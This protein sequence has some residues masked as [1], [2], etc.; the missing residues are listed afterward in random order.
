MIS[1]GN[2][3]VALNKVDAQRTNQFAFYSKILS[4]S[5]Q[6]LYNLAQCSG[7]PLEHYVWLLW[8]VKESAYK[9]LKRRNP[10]IIFSPAK[11][12]V[13]DAELCEAEPLTPGT[14]KLYKGKVSYGKSTLCFTS[15]ITAEWI[16][17]VVNDSSDFENICWQVAQVEDDKYQ[18]QYN[19]V[20]TLLIA[21]LNSLVPG[22][23][24][25]EKNP[26]GYPEI[27]KNSHKINIPISIA[28]HGLFVSYAFNLTDFKL[29]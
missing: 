12:I 14:Q 21:E 4:T 2:D 13:N 24:V 22:S 11:F 28:H 17:S 10:G 26:V 9:Y 1:A 19:A 27:I 8:S 15:K 3:I 20:R 7:L 5:E 6:A 23:L 18:Y 25:I 29:N 16:A